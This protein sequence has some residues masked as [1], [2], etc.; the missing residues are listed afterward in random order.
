MSTPYGPF[1]QALEHLSRAIDPEELQAAFGTAGGELNRLLPELPVRLGQPPARV[2][3]DPD[4]ERHRL[5]TAVTGLLDRVAS[6]RAVILLLEDTQ[7]A[8]TPT[9]LLL[10]HLARTAAG[11]LL[12]L[13]TFRE[14]EVN[15]PDPLA[16]TLAEFRRSD[17]VL[18]LSLTGLSGDEVIEFIKRA[19]SG[20]GTVD[21]GELASAISDP[22]NG[23]PFRLRALAGAVGDEGRTSHRWGDAVLASAHDPGSTG[24]CSRGRHRSTGSALLR[25]R[26]RA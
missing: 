9:V 22:T 4:T 13:A 23:N 25:D 11:P 6:R 7:W 1:T 5:H 24:R 18:R 8:D 16:R 10:R 21:G 17:D 12:I 14:S 20:L 3:A 26:D 2:N 15:V 19:G